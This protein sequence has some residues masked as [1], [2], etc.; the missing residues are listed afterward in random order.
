MAAL[1][2]S[3]EYSHVFALKKRVADEKG[4]R[5]YLASNR[6]QKFSKNGVFRHYPELD[7]DE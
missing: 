7:G 4:V 6:R 2:K 3:G 1:E 5:Q